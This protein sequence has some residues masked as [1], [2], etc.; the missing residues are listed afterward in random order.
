MTRRSRR[1]RGRDRGFSII[2]VMIAAAVF[3]IGA[4]GSLSVLAM[5]QRQYRHQNQLTQAIHLAEMQMEQTVLLYRDDVVSGGPRCF[6]A[7]GHQMS[8]G[9]HEY[10]ASWFVTSGVP[11]QGMKQIRVVVSWHEMAAT[12]QV[13]LLTYRE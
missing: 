2:E 3:A 12:K 13:S 10:A 1:I 4:A 7:Q 5:A 9:S 8:C 6:T 11:I